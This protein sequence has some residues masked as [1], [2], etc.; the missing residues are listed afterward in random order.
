MRVACAYVEH[1]KRYLFFTPDQCAQLIELL[2]NAD[3]VIS[4]NGKNFDSLVL[5]Q[6]HGLKGKLP[7]KGRHFDV[8]QVLSERAGFRVSLDVAAKINLGEG[9]HTQG[10]EMNNLNAAALREA[11]KAD[12]RQT[13]RLWKLHESGALQAPRKRPR[14]Y[15]RGD[16]LGGPGSFIPDIC[17]ICHDVGSLEF[18][19]WDGDDDMTD[20]QFAEYLAGTQGSAVCRTC[21][22]LI[23]WNV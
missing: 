22:H 14:T 16:G 1:Q 13:Y 15:D 7:A 5:R 20:G 3:E 11:C 21:N 17:P 19:D 4:F 2:Q 9:K 18:I 10:R 12:V 23:N 8:H 6:H